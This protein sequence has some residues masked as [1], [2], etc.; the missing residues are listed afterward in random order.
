MAS[1]T[2]KFDLEI[3]GVAT[4]PTSIVFRDA[5]GTYG[6]KRQDTDASVVAIDTAL[7][8]SSTGSYYYTFT[9]PAV[10]LTYD[11][12]IQYV[13]DGETYTEAKTISGGVSAS[14]NVYDLLPRIQP[15]LKG[16]PDNF[17]KQNLRRAVR[18]FARDTWAIEEDITVTGVASQRE[19]TLTSTYDASVLRVKDI[20]IDDVSVGFEM[21]DGSNL[22]KLNGAPATGDSVVCTCAILPDEDATGIPQPILDEWG[23]G[24][25]AGALR[26]LHEMEG[27]SWF[28]PNN[29]Q[30]CKWEY[31][32]A[33]GEAKRSLLRERMGDGIMRPR[34]PVC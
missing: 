7:T 18:N 26:L 32:R 22:I 13:Y 12:A 3:D 29:A 10:N 6:V 28:S 25:S 27:T 2:I 34:F 21:N 19:Y 31:V 24:I 30:I 14:D 20:K 1:T 9:D 33:T 4:N 8:N 5:G 16:C 23:D 15:R 17:V 11:Y